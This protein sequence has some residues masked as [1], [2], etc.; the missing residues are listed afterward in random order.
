[1]RAG[2]SRGTGSL[3]NKAGKLVLTAAHVVGTAKTANIYFPV[4]DDKGKPMNVNPIRRLPFLGDGWRRGLEFVDDAAERGLRILPQTS[5][6]QM[7]VF[8]ALHDTF[9]FDEMPVFRAVLTAPDRERQ[10]A[11]PSVRGTLRAAPEV[12][13]AAARG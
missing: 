8:F 3:V 7:Q 10:L 9:L 11:D 13:V 5:L 2:H 4:F 12:G 6:Q 1:M